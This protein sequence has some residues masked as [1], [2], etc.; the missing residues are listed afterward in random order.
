[1]QRCVCTRTRRFNAQGALRRVVLR[2][3]DLH[4]VSRGRR[5][6]HWIDRE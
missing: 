5:C 3:R 4:R 6:I 1:L 2:A